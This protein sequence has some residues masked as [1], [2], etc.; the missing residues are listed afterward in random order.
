VRDAVAGPFLGRCKELGNI[1]V[2]AEPL[3]LPQHVKH[4]HPADDVEQVV[5]E[6]CRQTDGRKI[7]LGN[8]DKYRGV[9]ASDD[10]TCEARTCVGRMGTFLRVARF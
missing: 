6:A 10:R 4:A 5:D 2:R 3:H 1:E 9:E 8:F 7:N